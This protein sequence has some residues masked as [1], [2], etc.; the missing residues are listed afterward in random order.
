MGEILNFLSMYCVR[1]NYTQGIDKKQQEMDGPSKV[2]H[3][4]YFT[5]VLV[6]T[7]AVG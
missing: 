7:G 2:N 6:Y 3:W 1:L 4:V 5:K